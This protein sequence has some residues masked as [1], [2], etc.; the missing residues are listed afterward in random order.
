MN[1][2]TKSK[3][4]KLIINTYLFLI[5]IFYNLYINFGFF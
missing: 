4:T 3:K 5:S 1:E 2:F